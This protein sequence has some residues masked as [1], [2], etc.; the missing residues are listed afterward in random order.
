M[1]ELGGETESLS[2]VVD[3]NP[4]LRHGLVSTAVTFLRNPKVVPRPK[5]EKETFLLKKGLTSAE[6][7]AAFKEAGVSDLQ[8]NA[9]YSSVQVARV[10][11]KYSTAVAPTYASRWTLIRDVLNT[12]VLLAGAAY[13]LHYL[14]KRF[15]AP[16][17]FG[18]RWKTK[19]VQETVTEMNTNLTQLVGELTTAVRNM[20]ETLVAQGQ[21]RD[22]K[23]EIGELKT[24]VASL[25]ALLLSRRQFPAPPPVGPPSI[26]AWQLAA[27]GSQKLDLSRLN[28]TSQVHAGANSV[29]GEGSLSSSPEIISVEDMPPGAAM[30]NQSLQL[31]PM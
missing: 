11:E 22:S 7:A 27:S 8:E 28:E 10:H 29:L 5:S 13:S 19:S 15:I 31:R 6:I 4:Q 17:L 25:K 26:P 9:H 16:W 2:P 30:A 24:E 18:G 21:K 23:S 1:S 12:V 3:V 14:Y 20:N